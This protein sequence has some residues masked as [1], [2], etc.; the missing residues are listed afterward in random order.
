[1]AR[2]R[3]SERDVLET[4]IRCGTK[5]WCYRSRE[6][7]TLANVRTVE[8]EHVTPLA[9]GGADTPEN[10]AY[11]LAVA[12]KLQSFGT[13]ATTVNSDIHKIAKVKRLRAGGKTRR[14]PQMKSRPF[15]KTHR[16]FPK[17]A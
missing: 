2:R 17:K 8:R 14:G 15:S 4:L 10:C 1:M 12:H 6:P 5:L 11:S 3:F 9:L 16:K 7:I 13:K